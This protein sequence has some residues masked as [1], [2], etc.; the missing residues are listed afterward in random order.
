MGDDSAKPA[1]KGGLKV[2]IAGAPASGKGTQVSSFS[3]EQGIWRNVLL[4]HQ[5]LVGAIRRD[6][7]A[8]L[9]VRRFRESCVR[10]V[11]PLSMFLILQCELIVEKYGL[12]HL[13]TGELLREE[14]RQ[15]TSAGR[16]AREFMDRGDQVPDEVRACCHKIP[17]CSAVWS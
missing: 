2:V 13:S 1:G 10:G 15:G 7:S 5:E 16:K 11:P 9:M 17:T 12:L 8:H 3:E 14:A 6:N 4:V